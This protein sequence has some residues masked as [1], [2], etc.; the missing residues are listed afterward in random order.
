MTDNKEKKDIEKY[1]L[2]YLKIELYYI[3]ENLSN[4]L[5]YLQI[6]FIT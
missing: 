2:K 3:Y 1:K 6:L 5:S 4:T